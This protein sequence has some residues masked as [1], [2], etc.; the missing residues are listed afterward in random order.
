MYNAS[1]KIYLGAFL[2]PFTGFLFGY[3][4][5]SIFR[6]KHFERR[7][8]ALETGIQNFPLCMTLLTMSFSRDRFAEI[9]LFPLLYG[10]TCILASVVFAVVYRVVKLIQVNFLQ[11]QK[12]RKNCNGIDIQEKVETTTRFLDKTDFVDA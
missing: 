7:T 2:L 12:A 10:V 4:V 6:M 3:V 11:K 5:A 8:V 9:S 1:W